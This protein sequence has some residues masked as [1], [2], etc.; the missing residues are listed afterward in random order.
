LETLFPLLD[1]FQSENI[2]I[3]PTKAEIQNFLKNYKKKHYEVID[4]ELVFKETIEDVIDIKKTMIC[5]VEGFELEIQYESL[6]EIFDHIF[7]T[8]NEEFK[9]LFNSTNNKIVQYVNEINEKDKF[10]VFKKIPTCYFQYLENEPICIEV[11]SDFN[12][13]KKNICQM[14][15][16][17]TIII[18]DNLESQKKII[19]K[20]EDLIFE[21]KYFVFEN[22][23]QLKNFKN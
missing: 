10:L 5:L 19:S 13:M 8:T 7:S 22:L 11:N 14:I 17:E 18:V 1:I 21:K 4:D 12:V 15:N 2:K 3:N 16:K 23:S 9:Y 20:Y 6:K